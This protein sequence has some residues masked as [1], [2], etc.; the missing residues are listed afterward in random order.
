MPWPDL[1]QGLRCVV[2]GGSGLQSCNLHEVVRS[3][4]VL[5]GA[6]HALYSKVNDVG[7][8]PAPTRSWM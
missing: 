6:S 4:T 2:G 1:Q 8:L 5:Q 7:T 3:Y